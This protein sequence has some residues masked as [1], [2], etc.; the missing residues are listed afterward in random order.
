M[1]TIKPRVSAIDS[2]AVHTDSTSAQTYGL[3]DTARDFE[4]TLQI[5]NSRLEAEYSLE[6]ALRHLL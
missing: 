6:T 3:S 5:L 1:D 4:Q 2:D